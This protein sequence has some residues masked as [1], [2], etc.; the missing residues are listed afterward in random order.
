MSIFLSNEKILSKIDQL[1]LIGYDQVRL[2]GGTSKDG[3]FYSGV[4]LL[5]YDPVNKS[6]FFLAVPYDSHYHRTGGEG[7]NNKRSDETPLETASRELFEETGV[8]VSE[9]D[10]FLFFSKDIPDNRPWKPKD[11]IHNR[12]FYVTD[13]FNEKNF[14]QFEGP[15]PI[16]A[17]TAAPIWIP[18]ELFMKV[19]YYGH[20]DAL[21]EAVNYLS[22]NR[23][24][25][26]ALM[27]L[28]T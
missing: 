20:L 28:L 26:Y 2:P 15:N 17:E 24:Y 10:I 21:K 23:V 14:F 11:S 5:K 22:S 25:A 8:S 7:N 19:I 3:S 1:K 16:N 9:K 12:F 18:A 13:K 6:I 27:N 4:V